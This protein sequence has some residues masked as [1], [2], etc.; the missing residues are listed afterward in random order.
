MESVFTVEINSIFP[1]RQVTSFRTLL[2]LDS[3]HCVECH[4]GFDNG[5]KALAASD[6][7][8][9]GGWSRSS[10]PSHYDEHDRGML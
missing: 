7:V 4:E 5:I 3:V 2:V 8:G 6:T 1:P 9:C 10:R